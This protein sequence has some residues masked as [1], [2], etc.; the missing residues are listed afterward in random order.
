HTI[1]GEGSLLWALHD[2][3]G[4]DLQLASYRDF[5]TSHQDV[6]GSWDLGDLQVTSFAVMGLAAVGGP[7]ANAAMVSAA[8]YFLAHQIASGGG[9]ARGRPT[10][11]EADTVGG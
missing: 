11:P 3:P 8:N 1:L 7:V 10:A 9:P 6:A 4:F 5:L 2:L